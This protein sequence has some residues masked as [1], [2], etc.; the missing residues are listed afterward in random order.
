[1]LVLTRK[2]NQSITLGDDITV[3]VLNVEGDRVSLGVDAPRSVRIFRSEL[4][5]GT[6]SENRASV[7]TEMTSLKAILAMKSEKKEK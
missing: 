3:T 6:K 7:G 4:L 5:E 1:M 2:L